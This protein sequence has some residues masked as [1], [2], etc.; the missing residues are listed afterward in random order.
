M[1]TDDEDWQPTPFYNVTFSPNL[2]GEHATAFAGYGKNL[3]LKAFQTLA[4]RA[5][6]DDW[7]SAQGM[8]ERIIDT[9]AD[10]ANLAKNFDGKP[11]TVKLIDKH[12]MA[13]RKSSQFLLNF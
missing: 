1:Q 6:F 5:G 7:Q 9:V 8:I 4:Q 13:I 2:Y 10:F 11:S 12:L 3:P